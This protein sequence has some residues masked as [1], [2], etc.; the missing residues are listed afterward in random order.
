MDEKSRGGRPPAQDP[1]GK[2]RG[3][4]FTESEAAEIDD[5]AERAGV[6]TARFIREAALKKARQK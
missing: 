5:A 1:L 6:K 3:V 4:R 2:V